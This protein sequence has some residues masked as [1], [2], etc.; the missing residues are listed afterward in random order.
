MSVRQIFQPALVGADV[1]RREMGADSC[2][3]LIVDLL[4]S[5][6]SVQSSALDVRREAPL[7]HP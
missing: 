1:R 6:L 5:T 7:A 3:V 4:T 2:T